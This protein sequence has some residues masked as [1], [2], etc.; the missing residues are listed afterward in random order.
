MKENIKENLKDNMKDNNKN[1]NN[2]SLTNRIEGEELYNIEEKKK[3]F[4]NE[5][6]LNNLSKKEGVKS[7]TFQNM[8]K[9]LNN[10]E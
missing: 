10:K 9:K 8:I 3:Y 1:S 2:L 5:N 6:L 4:E 7:T